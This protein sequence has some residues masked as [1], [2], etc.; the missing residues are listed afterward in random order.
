MWPLIMTN[1]EK[2]WTIQLALATFKGQYTVQWNLMLAAT[3]IS[4]LPLIIVFLFGQRYYIQGLVTSGVK[5]TKNTK[6]NV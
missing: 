1:S 3:V 6:K 4:I 2:M 5:G